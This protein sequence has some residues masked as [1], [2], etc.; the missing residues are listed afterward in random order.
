MYMFKLIIQASCNI[1]LSSGFGYVCT[2]KWIYCMYACI[3]PCGH[4]IAIQIQPWIYEKI[5][6][7]HLLYY[8]GICILMFCLHFCRTVLNKTF[9]WECKDLGVKFPSVKVINYV[10]LMQQRNIQVTWFLSSFM[11]PAVST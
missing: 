9:K 1:W 5:H 3:Y 8:I 10:P 7:Y 2:Y 4:K 6:L 11:L